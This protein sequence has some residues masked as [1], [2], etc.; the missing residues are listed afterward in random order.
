MAMSTA[1][2]MT[3]TRT[4][5][6]SLLLWKGRFNWFPTQAGRNTP[7]QLQPP[8][9]SEALWQPTVKSPV[10][11][12]IDG[13]RMGVA[14]VV[15]DPEREV[16]EREAVTVADETEDHPELAVRSRQVDLEA[17]WEFRAVTSFGITSAQSL[18][19]NAILLESTAS[20]AQRLGSSASA[21]HRVLGES[22]LVE[23]D[24]GITPP[25]GQGLPLAVCG[26]E[27]PVLCL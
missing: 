14:G 16:A 21:S 13:L 9:K 6:I 27:R 3:M 24:A 19:L 18:D 12:L 8:L 15:T 2:T 4:V 5:S 20:L 17:R 11:D 25:D 23:E 26:L 1:T 10:G 7:A 22:P